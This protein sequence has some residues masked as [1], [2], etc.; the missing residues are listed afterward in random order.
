MADHQDIEDVLVD[1]GKRQ[2]E[3]PLGFTATVMRGVEAVQAGLSPWR[4]WRRAGRATNLLRGTRV[5]TSHSHMRR[6]V[7]AAEGDNVGKKILLGVMGLGA[8][9]AVAMF[10]LGIPPVGD[11]T[12]G[13]IGAAKRYQGAALSDK[14]VVVGPM[15]VQQF[16]QS[17]TFDRIMKNDA[18][19]N[20]LMR[21]SQDVELQRMFG[22]PALM[23]AF[24]NAAFQQAF[25]NA[26]F[27]QAL[28]DVEFQQALGRFRFNDAALQQAVLNLE[29]QQAFA[30]LNMEKAF[31]NAAFQQAFSDLEFRR[32]FFSVEFQQALAMPA[33]QQALKVPGF[34]SALA[35]PAFQQAL[36]QPALMRALGEPAFQQAL[37]VRE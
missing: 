24:S 16:L 14:D 37:R 3:L 35:V 21:A 20:M 30:K 32:A 25:G 29:F 12:E 8:A 13:T 31:T 5:N 18:A 4:R 9:A 27:Q 34:M 2:P 17:D 36:A 7:T 26:A 10:F 15:E 1:A 11:G 33:F 19:R 28:L 23:E 6:P 22:E